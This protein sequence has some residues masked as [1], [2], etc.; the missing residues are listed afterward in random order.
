MTKKLLYPLFLLALL[1]PLSSCRNEEAADAED[2]LATVPADA[3]LVAVVNLHNILDNAGCK[4]DGSKV[5]PGDG[6]KDI[7]ATKATAGS[8]QKIKALFDGESGID[9][10]VA[11]LFMEGGYSYLV[12]QLADAGKFKSYIEANEKAKFTATG[13]V[14]CLRET[15]VKGNR[16][17]VNLGASGI[18][19]RT[20]DSFTELS[21]KQ[22]FLSNAYCDKLLKVENAVE[23]W[24][25]ISGLM[26]TADFDFQKKAMAQVALQ[27]VFQDPCD[28]AFSVKFEK[29]T[30]TMDYAPLN[31]KGKPAKSNFPTDRLD[32]KSIASI[33][34]T[35]DVVGGLAISQ[36]M[37]QTLQKSASE[38]G[39]SVFGIYLQSLSCL[40][41]TSGVALGTKDNAYSAFFT[42]N[43][44]NV[45]S[46]EDM[47]GSIVGTSPVR[48][49]NVLRLR[50]GAVSGPLDVSKAAGN[51]KGA[52]IGFTGRVDRAG[53][54]PPF[55]MTFMLVPADGS[56]RVVLKASTLDPKEKFLLTFLKNMK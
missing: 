35:A 33:G 43:G 13:D 36:K 12:G 17:W 22:S 16:F 51:L 49:G 45:A 34:G 23:G 24:A 44:K 32:V 14:A 55:D 56:L 2:L 41:G 27:T 20:V 37:V 1:L 21:E 42:T 8:R 7:I 39:P 38:K 53:G 40:D 15:A 11:V 30:C 47:L 29:N 6:L 25:S 52:M 19:P 31:S 5:V 50:K 26:N 3:S 9:P 46:L 28:V 4:V 18:D 10:S 54:M 48:E